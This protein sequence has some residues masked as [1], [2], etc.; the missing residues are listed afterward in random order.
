MFSVLN[1]VCFVGNLLEIHQG[2]TKN[3][4]NLLSG[5]PRQ[6]FEDSIPSVCRS[7]PTDAGG[8][9]DSCV[10]PLLMPM[11]EPFVAVSPLIVNTFTLR[12]VCQQSILHIQRFLIYATH[13]HVI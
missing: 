7:V 8:F 10:K 12:F 1:T 6:H 13:T 11:E 4:S 9:C 2:T 3:K 5:K